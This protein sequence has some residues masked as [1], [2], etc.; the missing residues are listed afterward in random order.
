MEYWGLRSLER[1]IFFCIYDL[2][3]F[4]GDMWLYEMICEKLFC[5]DLVI[6]VVR[7]KLTFLFMLLWVIL[8]FSFFLDRFKVVLRGV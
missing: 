4:L 8:Y 3:S 5:K 1:G 2:G 7:I 6:S